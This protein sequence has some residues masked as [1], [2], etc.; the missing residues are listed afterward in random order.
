MD[1]S[2]KTK[3]AVGFKKQEDDGNGDVVFNSGAN[4][5]D[6]VNFG[7][8]DALDDGEFVQKQ[9]E[10]NIIR[11]LPDFMATLLTFHYRS[12]LSSPY[13]KKVSNPHSGSTR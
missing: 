9:R 12:L 4:N 8:A 3:K 5:M 11:K 7:G 1:E 10:N 2:K 6:L 13:R